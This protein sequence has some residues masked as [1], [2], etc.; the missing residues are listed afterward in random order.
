MIKTVSVT[1]ENGDTLEMSLTNPWRNGYAITNMDGI[2]EAEANISLLEN[3][4]IDG[5]LF[6][7]SRIPNRNITMTIKPLAQPT[8]ENR[9]L[10]I[11]RYFQTKRKHKIR[12][13]TDSR[14]VEIIGYL[15]TLG[16]SP[17][18]NDERFTASFICPDPYFYSRVGSDYPNR[19]SVS[20]VNPLFTFPFTNPYGEKT[21]IFS[22]R[23]SDTYAQFNYFGDAITG[24]NINI[25]IDTDI[26]DDILVYSRTTNQSMVLSPSGVKSIAPELANRTGFISGDQ[27]VIDTRDY[28]KD[29]KLFVSGVEYNAY[30]IVSDIFDWINI[31]P[32]LNDVGYELVDPTSIIS[33]SIA[34]T[35]KYLGV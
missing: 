13:E 27:I 4:N 25:H 18:S 33:M 32:G 16:G 15:E 3:A 21:L 19:V 17:F 8:V 20:D 12:I 5:D 24:I 6:A 26:N 34:Y 23:L 35:E 14:N 30:A 28:Y 7:S 2:T 29:V 9:R 31:V 22:E 1:N 11:Y 10:N